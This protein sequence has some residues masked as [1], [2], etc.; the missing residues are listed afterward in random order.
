MRCL[1]GVGLV[2]SITA[3]ASA[4]LVQSDPLTT[5]ITTGLESKYSVAGLPRQ[6]HLLADQMRRYRVPAVSV[7]VIDNYR[8]AW[9]YATGFRDVA[10]HA[11]ALTTTLFQAASMSKPVAAAAILRLFQE[12]RLD[13]D[14]DVNT[15][16]HSWRVPVRNSSEHVTMRRLL[17]HNAGINVHGFAGYDRDAALPTLV[18]VLDGVPPANN[19]P[20]RVVAT[21][22]SLT[23]YS[24]GGTSIAQQLAVDV[25][26]RPFATFMQQTLLGPLGMTNSTFDQPLAETLWPR[27][28]DGYY[29]DGRPVHRGWHVYP[30]MAAAGLWT[31]P[32]DLATFVIAI[33]N[34]LRGRGK[35]PIDSSVAREM[36]TR[37]SQ[38]FG[39]G[40]SVQ[41]AYF[42]HNGANE[43]FQGIFLGLKRGGRGVVVMTDSDNGLL[44]ADEIVHSVAKAYHWPV[45]QPQAKPAISLNAAAMQRIVGKY[46]AKFAG[47]SVTLDVTLGKSQGAPALFLRSSLDGFEHEMYAETP[48]RFFTLNGAS[49]AFSRETPAKAMSVEAEGTRFERLP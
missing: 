46:S 22:G 1:I 31:T 19:D 17:S 27:A 47:E 44:L 12:K 48:T 14:G 29:S 25:A 40:L 43:G 39:L 23:D 7:A 13:L 6:R 4:A 32:S 41:A 45:F 8:I 18:Q 5:Q 37:A 42:A 28:A 16:L 24:G 3:T 35:V 20:I 36:T 15:M 11:P 38:G 9:I 34:A 2:A 21:P 10:S 33:Q 49:L 30:T 26:G